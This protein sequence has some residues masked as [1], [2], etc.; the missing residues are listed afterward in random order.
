MDKIYALRCFCTAAETLQF[1]EAAS[2][3]A[4]SPQVVTRVISE[5][6]DLLGEELFKRN[7]RNMRLTLFGEEFLPNAL[8]VLD[9]CENLFST[10]MLNQRELNGPVR[11]T[12]PEL[13]DNRE[14][15][16]ELFGALSKFPGI[17]I[18]WRVDSAKLNLVE[19]QIDIGLRISSQPDR[20]YIAR[21][22]CQIKEV[23][24]ASPLLVEKCGLPKDLADLERN[25]PVSALIDYST[26]RAWPWQIAEDLTLHPK[27]PHFLTDDFAS[28]LSSAIAGHT[29]G[30]LIERFCEP[31]L[32]EGKLI[33]VFPQLT[34]PRWE[35]YLFRPQSSATPKRVKIVFDILF[36]ILQSRYNDNSDN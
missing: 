12:L 5:L 19:E 3:L 1:K 14:I 16:S 28:Q 18:D 33:R 4:V 15:L 35:M 17:I 2:K 6:E 29:F 22:V 34:Q 7:T 21:R 31:Y 13:P 8:R 25:Y 36:T 24:V 27:N 23:I 20:R 32:S 26:G 30:H 11:I 10:E 9:D